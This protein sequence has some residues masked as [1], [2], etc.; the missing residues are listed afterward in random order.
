MIFGLFITL[1]ASSYVPFIFLLGILGPFAFLGYL[2][3]FFLILR[4]HGLLL[5]PLGFPGPI[6][7]FFILGAHGPSINPLLSLFA[8]LR[9]YCGS[10]SLFYI[11]Y[12]P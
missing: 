4:S 10:F 3:P 8:L 11:T 12:C 6:T 1:L 2:R 9:A 7:L 5:T